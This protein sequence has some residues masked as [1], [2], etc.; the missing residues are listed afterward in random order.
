MPKS[1]WQRYQRQRISR[2]RLL[3]MAGLGATGLVVGAA[4]D[5][6]DGEPGPAGTPAA[7]STP[8]AEGTPKRGGTY[9]S[10]NTGDWGTIDPVTTVG[11]GTAIMPYLYNVLLS[12]SNMNPDFFFFDLAE[13]LEQPDEVTYVF[14]IRRGVKIAPNDLGIPERDMDALDCT[15]WDERIF[16]DEDALARSV[17]LKWLDSSEAPD[18]YT[19]VQKTKEPYAYFIAEQGR[20]LGRCIPPREF[21]ERGI[22]LENQGVGAGFRVLRPGTYRETGS[23]ILD[24]NP[25]YYRKDETTGEQLPYMDVVDVV[26]ITERQARRTAFLDQQIYNYAAESG[27]EAEEILRQ[28]PNTY[29]VRNPSFLFIS[30]T[31]NVT[32]EPWND[33][34]IRKAAL[35]ALD[36][37]EF[38]DLIV[39][40][41][42]GKPNGLVHWPT[43]RYAFSEEELEEFQPHD[44][45]RSRELI[46][47]ATGEDTIRVKITY[48]VTD[49]EYHD[50]HLPIFLKQMREAGFDIEEDPKDFGQWLGDYT[51]VRYDASLSPNQQYETPRIVLDW[52]S[53]K[54][55]QG[56]ENFAIGVGALHPEIDEA[57]AD[58]KRV[59]DPEEHI[60]KV[61]DVQR[62]IYETGPSFLPI[63]CPYTHTLYWDF[64]KN[65]PQGLGD[66]GLLLAS[67]TWLD[68]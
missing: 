59:T 65:V 43:G 50:D 44:P 6:G 31:M 20:A 57:I 30:F 12:R 16:T 23:L 26:L 53:S 36:R 55:P 17:S 48:P 66:T 22:S 37:R 4:C 67:E 19:F 27:S 3:A 58:S 45:Q 13:S 60:Q 46:R 29:V 62:L 15:K 54:G 68:L 42:G 38:I 14:N 5:G 9:K 25:N 40:P 56:D 35:Y 51:R 49:L 41:E 47:A 63:F 21:F 64:V 28:K 2:R 11:T 34:R 7:G 24:R 61:R 1:Y 33:D 32:R 8:A 39:G 18:N 52:Q 10:V